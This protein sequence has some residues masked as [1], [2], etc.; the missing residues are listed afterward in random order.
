MTAIISALDN[1][2]PSQIGEKG[3][4]EY[5]WSN[6]IRE[7]IVQLS[8]QLTRTTDKNTIENLSVKTE[9]I[10]KDIANSY[11]SSWQV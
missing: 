1:F 7:N 8:F 9:K 3:S 6:N 2:T 5:T 10:L 4:I 11:K